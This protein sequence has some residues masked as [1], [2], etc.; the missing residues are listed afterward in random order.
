METTSSGLT[1]F[2]SQPY[3]ERQ[4]IV[5]V[6]DAL[7]EAEREARATAEK[8]GQ[9]VDLAQ[10]ATAI[11]SVALGGVTLLAIEVVR[12]AAKAREAG[13]PL[14]TVSRSEA[15]ALTLPPG[16]HVT[17]SSTLAIRRSRRRT[18]RLRRSIA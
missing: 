12:A 16:I 11:A 14:F 4:R 9:G 17:V 6:D 13:V 5:I 18:I 10:I 2:L 7:V 8:S 3:A 15:Q 1:E